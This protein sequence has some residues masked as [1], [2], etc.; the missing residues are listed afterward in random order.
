MAPCMGQAGE[1][2]PGSHSASHVSDTPVAPLLRTPSAP[3]PSLRPTHI[4]GLT[5][6]CKLC[7]EDR[8]GLHWGWEDARGPAASHRGSPCR[9]LPSQGAFSAGAAGTSFSWAPLGRSEADTAPGN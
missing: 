1:L 2:A 5:P 8:R 6:P 4:L 7:L 9:G 3:L